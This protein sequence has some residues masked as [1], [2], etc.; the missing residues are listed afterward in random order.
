[1]IGG[2]FFIAFKTN[3]EMFVFDPAAFGISGL[4]FANGTIDAIPSNANVIVLLATDNDNNPLTPFGA[5]NAADLIAGKVTTAGPGALH[6][7]HPEPE[8]TATGL[9]RQPGEQHC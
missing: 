6:L 8:P 7:F 5:G 3:T 4:R 1:M 9:F 2:E